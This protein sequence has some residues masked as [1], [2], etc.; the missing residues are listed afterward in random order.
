M[1]RRWLWVVLLAA[2]IAG[3]TTYWVSAQQP[4]FYEAQAR[5]IVGPGIDSLNPELNDLRTGGQ[6]LQTY[7]ELTTSRPVLQQVIDQLG[8]N[9]EPAVL[10][11]G[12]TVRADQE[13]QFLSVK[14]EDGNP[15]QAA[16]I[17]NAIAE[18]L[19][20]LSPS[21]SGGT[22]AQLQDR[23]GDQAR[24]IEDNIASIEVQIV[25]LEFEFDA[26][27]DVVQKRLITD[28]LSQQRTRLVDAHATLALLYDSLQKAS[29]NKV[30]LV[31]PAIVG[32]QVNSQ[33][34]LKVII[35]AIAGLILSISVVLVYEFFDDATV[36]TTEGAGKLTKLPTLVGIGEIR[37]SEDALVTLSQPRS[38][39]SEAFRVLRTSIQFSSVDNPN[40]TLL[41]TSSIPGEGKSTTAA[42]LAVVM[43]QAGHNV[44]L[45]D[46]DLRRPM[47]DQIFELP[48]R[49]GLT[50]LLLEFNVSDGEQNVRA[51]LND[52]VQETRVEG[53]H[54]LSSGP[55][56]PNPS[57]LLGSTKMKTL[58]H[59]LATSYDY[60]I[61]DSPAV[62]A[63][64]DAAVLSVLAD[65][66]LVAALAG[67]SRKT[68]LSQ[69]VEQLREVNAN[70][71]GVILNGLSAKSDSYGM[72]YREA[73][74]GYNL[75][76]S[77]PKRSWF[78]RS[79]EKQKAAP[80][81]L[82]AGKSAD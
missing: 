49:R 31:E 21:G 58:L 12:I 45:V 79:R 80:K 3:G 68:H 34:N 1:I 30:R 14:V 55:V 82:T 27:N 35:G 22:A 25:Q 33:I 60:V 20:Q 43:A 70:L 75:N 81:T 28:E 7:A 15:E 4:V 72:Y 40:R 6:L 59:A 73:A 39:I 78:G 44:L 18:R 52:V 17:A 54:L 47:Q 38:P 62:L 69:A 46:T 11:H 9:V 65:G 10:E 23:M 50:S 5:L 51:L 71:M 32:E 63:A 74:S 48:N 19:V 8:L 61:L 57:E 67:K 36:K 76:A 53:L 16:T 26:T 64:T 13:T 24:R 66:T 77:A 42:N 37:T 2:V 29:T 56:P 41:V